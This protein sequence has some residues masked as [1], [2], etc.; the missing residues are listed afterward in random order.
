MKEVM[1]VAIN[2]CDLGIAVAQFTHDGNTGKSTA[3]N[4][5]LA[6]RCPC[7][8]GE[9]VGAHATPPCISETCCGLLIALSK[10][11]R[12]RGVWRSSQFAKANSA[13]RCGRLHDA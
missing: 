1:P 13:A 5:Y 3:N 2:E 10:G 12:E 11:L 4:H 8:R 9:V 6:P 7:G